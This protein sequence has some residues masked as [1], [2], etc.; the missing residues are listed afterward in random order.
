MPGKQVVYLLFSQKSEGGLPNNCVLDKELT[1]C[2]HRTASVEPLLGVS[3]RPFLSP[4]VSGQLDT[5][6]C[7]ILGPLAFH[8]YGHLEKY[9]MKMENNFLKRKIGDYFLVT[10]HALKPVEL[11]FIEGELILSQKLF[12]SGAWGVGSL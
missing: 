5:T 4:T 2:H 11:Y 12:Y 10:E 6:C 8:F 7:R 9:L 1:K 3:R